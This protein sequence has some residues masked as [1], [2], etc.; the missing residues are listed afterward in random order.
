MPTPANKSKWYSK[1]EKCTLCGE[2]ATL[3][4]IL[5]C[6]RIA[7][8]QGRYTW[9]HNKVLSEVANSLQ[10][11]LVE[12]CNTTEKIRQ[13]CFSIKFNTTQ[14]LQNVWIFHRF[15]E[16]KENSITRCLDEKYG[17][18]ENVTYTR[19]DLFEQ[20]YPDQQTCSVQHIFS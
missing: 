8:A 3:N 7:L 6:C 15:W 17:E 12:N 13:T 9:R 19:H 1:E 10:V 16:P 14:T 5:S 20:N 18:N 4:H 2:E 11:R